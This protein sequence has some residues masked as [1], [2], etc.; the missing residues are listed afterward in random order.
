MPVMF[1]LFERLKKKERLIL[2]QVLVK[3]IIVDLQGEIIDHELNS[4]FAYFGSIVDHFQYQDSK[5][6][7]SEQVQAPLLNRNRRS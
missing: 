6:G 2:L 4:P 7:G 1:Q 5:I 3:R